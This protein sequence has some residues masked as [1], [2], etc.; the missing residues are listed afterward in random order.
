MP[1]RKQEV[2]KP[3]K[4]ITKLNS[5]QNVAP[6]ST[7]TLEMALGLSYDFLL[8]ELTNITLA[9]LSNIELRINGKAVQEF[10]TG[11]ELD[12]IN[13]FHG[14]Q[15]FA[16]GVLPMFFMRPE[17][18]LPG[19]KRVTSIGTA[20]IATLSLHMDIDGACVSPAIDITAQQ[21][22]QTPLGAIT[23]IRAFPGSA[24]TSGEFEI[25][26][27]PRSGARIA[28]IHLFKADVSHVLVKANG[29]EA[30]DASKTVLEK[31]HEIFDKTPITASCTHVDF[32]NNGSIQ[33]AM[34]TQ[35][36]QDLLVRPTLDTSG[37]L[38]TV[39]EFIEQF[40]GL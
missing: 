38:R 21:S 36:L 26:N 28:C 17:L 5:V 39:V 35:G 20:D 6:G 29:R 8:I 10:A 1:G 31:S 4:K 24:A 30:V 25:T 23:K 7:A 18:T 3:L 40:A 33:D 13:K 9:Q 2:L 37:S 19:E 34:I 32:I 11:T 12:N 14:R 15:A 27:I 16:D 22:A